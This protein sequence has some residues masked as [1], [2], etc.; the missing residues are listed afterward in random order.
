VVKTEVAICLNDE[1]EI[2]WK[3][4]IMRYLKI[5]SR[6]ISVISKENHKTVF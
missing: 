2:M 6:H 3:E 5:L 4:P 1:V